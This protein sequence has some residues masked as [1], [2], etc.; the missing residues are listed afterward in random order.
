MKPLL[1]FLTHNF[2]VRVQEKDLAFI[3]IGS[4]TKHVIILQDKWHQLGHMYVNIGAKEVAEQLKMT[5]LE[6]RDLLLAHGATKK[7][8]EK[9]KTTIV[10]W[11]LVG[12]LTA[13]IW[14]T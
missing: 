3:E 2:T 13:V 11:G 10:L 5:P 7:K 6:L 8:R 4:C 1:K 12:V 9:I 14:H